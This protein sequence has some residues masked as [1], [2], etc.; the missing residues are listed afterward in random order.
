MLWL[1]L[2]LTS[3]AERVDV[4]GKA[5]VMALEPQLE[6]MSEIALVQELEDLLVW[7]LD[8]TLEIAWFVD[9]EGAMALTW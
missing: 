8:P 7:V 6:Q 2:D 9:F 4:L 5:L 3:E 1:E